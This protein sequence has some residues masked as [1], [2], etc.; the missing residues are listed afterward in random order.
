MRMMRELKRIKPRSGAPLPHALFVFAALIAVIS[1][2]HALSPQEIYRQ[3]EH[4]V[5]VL[6]ALNAQGEVVSFHSAVLVGVDT[7]ATQCSALEGAAGLRLRRGS[8]S[9]VAQSS[10]KDS[11]R[12]L[13]LLKAP[14][15][16]DAPVKLIDDLPRTGAQAYAVSNPLGL[17]IGI[18]EGI[19]S[20]V[21][22]ERDESFIQFT[23]AIAPGSEGGG[24]FD[25]EGRLIGLISYR[26]RDGQ[27][28]NFAFPARWLKEIGARAAS[29]DA[30]EGWRAKAIELERQENW[31]GL[32]AHATAWTK[33]LADS[34]EAWLWLG[35][36]QFHRQDWPS[37]EHA[38]RQALHYEPSTIE[39]GVALTRTLLARK[40]A[41][42]ALEVARGMF[43]YRTEDAH[44]WLAVGLAE[45][46]LGQTAEAR[47]AFGQVIQLEPWNAEAYAALVDL[48]RVSGDWAG[49][50]LAQRQWAE[51]DSENPASWAGLAE[52]YSHAGRPERALASAERAL[53]L[54]PGNAD[55]WLAKGVALHGVKRDHEA[56]DALRKSI[57]LQTEPN[58]KP[59]GS[60]GDVY[61]EL[62]MLP[63][64]LAA[65]REGLRLAPDDA[66]LRLR[67]GIALSGDRQFT[68]ALRWF[69]KLRDEHP[70]NA[71][72]WR[73]LGS[74]WLSMARPEAAIAAF[75]K[76]L[77]LDRKQAVVWLSL[78]YAYH[79][80]DRRDDVRRAYQ[81][82]S[83]LDTASAETGYRQW[84]LPYG[85]AP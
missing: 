11:A 45:R 58:P 84:I 76:S 1:D 48:A 32:A 52:L 71:F 75:E 47:Q 69:E 60:L 10:Q 13:C 17:G 70:D 35:D 40:Q 67:Y 19:V 3:A 65:Y 46:A 82:L 41:A 34:A 85:V 21:R 78:M 24:L 62:N 81:N 9:Y 25:A 26:Q 8:S 72:V 37:A 44:V 63:E 31:D 73:Q 14:G 51:A 68:E 22:T 80:A 18:A 5:F 56:I 30:A 38:Y 64:S 27:N 7:V 54:A 43:A 57:A 66:G 6:E 83:T 39:A 79:L 59:W 29:V 77:N 12:N 28:V 33:A 74:T 23:A 20:G 55:A 42:A 16:G 50:L 36:A 15:A 49:A 4:Q 61:Y 53:A 2:A